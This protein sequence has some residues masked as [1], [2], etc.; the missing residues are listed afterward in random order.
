M[1]IFVKIDDPYQ[2]NDPCRTLATSIQTTLP[3]TTSRRCRGKQLVDGEKEEMVTE[4]PQ[5][6]NKEEKFC[7]GPFFG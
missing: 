1:L 7:A 5:Q 4:H 3:A 2:P 6:D